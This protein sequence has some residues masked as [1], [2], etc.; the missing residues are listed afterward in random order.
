MALTARYEQITGVR[1]QEQMPAMLVALG[2]GSTHWIGTAFYMLLPWIRE[3]LGINYLLAGSLVAATHLSSLLA[4]FGSSALTDVTG[5][6]ILILCFSLVLGAIALIGT[7]FIDH[8][9]ELGILIAVAGATGHVWHPA[10]ISY[11]SRLYP[12]QRGFALSAHSLGASLGDAMAPLILGM[13]LSVM[14]WK[15]AAF[16]AGLPVFGVVILLWWILG[17]EENPENRF[18]EKGAWRLYFKNLKK[19]GRHKPLILLSLV[20]G[21][22]GAA[23]TGLMMFIPIYL[24]DDLKAGSMITGLGFAALQIGGVVAAPITGLLSDRLGRKPII[25]FSL[26]GSTLM[27]ALMAMADQI[28]FFIPC[29]LILG[30]L[31]FAVRPV[32][33]SWCMDLAPKAMAGSAIGILFGV[34][35]VFAMLTPP[36]TGAVADEW[37]ISQVFWM[38]SMLV[39][40]STVFAILVPG[41]IPE[42]TDDSANI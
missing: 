35:S 7:S 28:E 23:Q 9:L 40:I 24:A 33:H 16:S 37:G 21:F 11:L 36:I 6:R 2:H 8:P 42:K 5:R 39:L 32:E 12:N 17:R 31:L 15:T 41:R 20:S 13:L 4:N 19:L 25:L 10:A 22:H 14:L 26:A 27:T 38:I 34:A 30:F 1:L 29:V 18:S 3:D